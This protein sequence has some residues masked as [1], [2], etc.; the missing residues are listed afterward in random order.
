MDKANS[1][2]LGLILQVALLTFSVLEMTR[3]GVMRAVME[4]ASVLSASG[5]QN[6]PEVRQNYDT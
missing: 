2:V 6:I 1:F 4:R 5:L 3:T